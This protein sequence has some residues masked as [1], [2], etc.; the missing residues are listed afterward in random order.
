MLSNVAQIPGIFG[1]VWVWRWTQYVCVSNIEANLWS[2]W[3]VFR[4]GDS[5]DLLSENRPICF[6]TKLR[7]FIFMKSSLK[8]RSKNFFPTVAYR[9][10][11]QL[12]PAISAVHTYWSRKTS[13]NIATNNVVL[14]LESCSLVSANAFNANVSIANF[15]LLQV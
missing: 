13:L 4:I 5:K 1:L 7:S 3:R 6:T 11:L 10:R 9:D 12:L 2:N 8:S 15:T 14:T